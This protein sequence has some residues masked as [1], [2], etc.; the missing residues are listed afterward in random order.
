VVTAYVMKLLELNAR[1]PPVLG[2][3][4]LLSAVER[5][6]SSLGIIK[7]FFLANSGL[8]GLL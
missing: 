3:G 4:G 2:L 8:A 1:L 6:L 5:S 7:D